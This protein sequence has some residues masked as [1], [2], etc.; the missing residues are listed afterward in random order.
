MEPAITCFIFEEKCP[1]ASVLTL[2]AD[3][4]S[5]VDLITAVVCD[6]TAAC[7]K[8]AMTTTRALMFC[9]SSEL[10]K[11]WLPVHVDLHALQVDPLRTVTVPR[12]MYMQLSLQP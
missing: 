11:R 6:E 4:D 1:H 9:S 12:Y 5:Y 2:S 10:L 3:L 7:N 8:H